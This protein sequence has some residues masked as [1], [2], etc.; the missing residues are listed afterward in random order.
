MSLQKS[1]LLALACSACSWQVGAQ[2]VLGGERVEFKTD[3]KR[4]L[5]DG[6]VLVEAEDGGILIQSRDQVIWAVQ[7]EAIISRL[8][9]DESHQ[10]LSS[11]E[12]ASSVLKELPADFR[13]H[14]TV[15]YVICYNTTKAYAEWCGSLYERLHRAFMNYW[16]RRGIKLQKTPPL[17]ACL[18]QDRKTYEDY[19]RD[20]LGKAIGS[21]IG[22]YSYKTNRIAMYDLT[23]LDNM[24]GRLRSAAH[25]NQLL[26]RPQT[27]RTVATIIHEATHQLA[28]NCGLHQ[29]YADIPLWLSEGLAIYFESHDLNSSRG[30]RTIGAV[31][32][33]RLGQFRKYLW[34]GR[35]D[36]SL[37]SLL[38]TDD[39][40]RD[41][42]LATDAYAECWAFCYYLIRNHPREFVHYLELLQAKTPLQTDTAQQRLGDFRTAFGTDPQQLNRDFLRQ[43]QRIH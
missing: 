42:S 30:W 21:V 27:E 19:G 32:R 16:T 13:V 11:T 29:R 25:V 38:A 43:T 40:F 6:E 14:A 4:H 22:F 17:V 9:H 24:R 8:V 20:E 23:G 2:R 7:P 10:P 33:V 39:R 18:F 34:R 3:G 1:L 15:H 41:T 35:P 5:V 12:L 37:V 28:F 26:R 36:E 31:N